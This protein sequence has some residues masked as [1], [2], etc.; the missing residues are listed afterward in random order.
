[1][2]VVETIHGIVEVEKAALTLEAFSAGG[3]LQV[4]WPRWKVKINVGEV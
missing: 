2:G 4:K 1:M 3:I